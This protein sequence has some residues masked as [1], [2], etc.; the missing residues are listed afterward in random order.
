[1]KIRCLAGIVL[2]I[3]AFCGCSKNPC[4]NTDLID[5]S[6][7]CPQHYAPVCGCDNITYQNE[8]VAQKRG[9]TYYNPGACL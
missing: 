8:C 4:I 2:M 9:V 7:V 1:M 3:V 5:S 6:V